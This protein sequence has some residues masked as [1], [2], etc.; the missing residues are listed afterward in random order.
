MAWFAKSAKRESFL[1]HAS[2]HISPHNILS[3]WVGVE[4]GFLTILISKMCE[5]CSTK[6]T[7]GISANDYHGA[8]RPKLTLYSTESNNIYSIKSVKESFISCQ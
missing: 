7:S 1:I 5:L 3:T 8:I 6:T 4:D 2:T